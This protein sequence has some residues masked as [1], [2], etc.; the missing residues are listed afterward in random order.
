MIMAH[1]LVPFLNCLA[2]ADNLAMSELV[3]GRVDCNGDGLL[4]TGKAI[5]YKP[6]GEAFDQ[7]GLLGILNGFL[8]HQGVVGRVV[9][10]W[11]EHG[12]LSFL[13]G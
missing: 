10:I 13:E 4:N 6:E 7:I 5:V 3:E 9:A 2:E 11:D 8:M 1:D 12:T